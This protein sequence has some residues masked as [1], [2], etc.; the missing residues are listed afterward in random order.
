M[1]DLDLI[2]EVEQGV[3]DRRGRFALPG[4]LVSTAPRPAPDAK[5]G[6][7]AAGVARFLLVPARRPVGRAVAPVAGPAGQPFESGV[8]GH[9]FENPAEVVALVGHE[10]QFGTVGHDL[11]QLVQCRARHD[12][13][14][15]LPALGPR[16]REQDEHAVDRGRRQRRHDQPCII[17]KD[18]NVVEPPPLDLGKQL[19]Y[20][21]LK[22]LAA[23]EPGLRMLLGQL[24]D[25]LTT[26]EPDLEP[27]RGSRG[28][29]EGIRVE[30][31]RCREVYRQPRQQFADKRLLSRTQSPPAAAA[32]DLVALL[33][34]GARYPQKARRSSSTRSN[35]SHEKPPSGSGRRPKWP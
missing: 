26:A 34:L 27:N 3:R 23:D 19:D 29:K 35:L 4:K 25:M 5:K 15:V 10:S 12:P 18:P 8:G 16:V 9:P 14:L 6:G 13:A 33:R 2:K 11:G 31:T 20:A 24:R 32:E 17:G 1:P 21:V 22:H 28:T 30:V 7:P